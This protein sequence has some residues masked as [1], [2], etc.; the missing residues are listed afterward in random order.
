MN[1]T[2]YALTIAAIFAVGAAGAVLTRLTPGVEVGVD[3]P[4]GGLAIATQF[5]GTLNDPSG[6]PFSGDLRVQIR[7]PAVSGGNLSATS[8][9][10]V[11]ANGAFDFEGWPRDA[12]SSSSE[13][14]FVASGS[15]A[16]P[17]GESPL[18]QLYST[19]T[20]LM[21]VV[22]PGVALDF[23]ATSSHTVALG[24][25]Q[26]ATAPS[27]GSFKIDDPDGALDGTPAVVHYCL[28]TSG[29]LEHQAPGALSSGDEWQ[30]LSGS[31]LVG[32]TYAVFSWSTVSIPFQLH[33]RSTQDPDF[34]AT[35]ALQGTGIT[36]LFLGDSR[37]VIGNVSP[38]LI[39]AGGAVV[40]VEPVADIAAPS[41][42]TFDLEFLLPR[43]LADVDPVTGD[44]TA[45]D[46]AKGIYHV[47]LM[48]SATTSVVDE[49][50]NVS[51]IN[52]GS[53]TVNFP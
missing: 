17:D 38:S 34:A 41:P 28:T 8:I 35:D 20:D 26:L 16:L 12:F 30:L 25:L 49:E 42:V 7:Q 39:A 13:L 9:E 43:Y 44:Y 48:N 3:T 45:L 40:V 19:G 47:R 22:V 18:T 50:L 51:V 46:V 37:S 24:T 27:I 29:A 36:G 21:R 6:V 15:G 32:S 4:A 1:K 53:A 52:T 11:V 23:S 5:T 33:V 10:T 31:F 14:T 2:T